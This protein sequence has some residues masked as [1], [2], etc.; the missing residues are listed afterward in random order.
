MFRILFLAILFCDV[1][2]NDNTHG[3]C[4]EECHVVLLDISGKILNIGLKDWI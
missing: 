3:N 1:Y 2:L 4:F